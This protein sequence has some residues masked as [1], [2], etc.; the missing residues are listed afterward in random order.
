MTSEPQY[1]PPFELWKT[2]HGVDGWDAKTWLVARFTHRKKAMEYLRARGYTF[3][4][5]SYYAHENENQRHCMGK[6]TYEI[7]PAKTNMILV[8]PK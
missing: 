6:I 1:V 7:R 4:E 2:D 8:D 3:L 5:G